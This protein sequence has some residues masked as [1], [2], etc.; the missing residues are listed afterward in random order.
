MINA[1]LTPQLVDLVANGL[2]KVR[3]WVILKNYILIFQ[4]E[5][6]Q[7]DAIYDDGWGVNCTMTK[8]QKF[9]NELVL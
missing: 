8:L 6:N 9:W 2:E 5:G 4:N 7:L 3:V 1:Q